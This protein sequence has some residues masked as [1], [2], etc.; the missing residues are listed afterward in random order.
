MKKSYNVCLIFLLL[1]GC[2]NTETNVDDLINITASRIDTISFNPLKWKVITSAI[3]NADNTQ[4]ILYGNDLAVG[5]AR[6]NASKLY[7]TGS[8]LCLVTWSQQNDKH[9]YGAKIPYEIVSIELITF[10]SNSKNSPLKIYEKYAGKPLQKL[11]EPDSTYKAQR[12][13]YIISQN[14]SVIP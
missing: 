12:I 5:F 11:N 14:A 13:N 6:S 10:D 8:K 7:P 1:L 4:S 9:W 3:S 2:V